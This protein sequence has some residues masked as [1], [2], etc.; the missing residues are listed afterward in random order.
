MEK[1]ETQSQAE[2]SGKEIE[3]VVSPPKLDYQR[4]APN[5]PEPVREP[6]REPP[7][8]PESAP[9]KT[10]KPETE[11]E[12]TKA[13][14]PTPVVPIAKAGAKRKFGDENDIRVVKVPP[15][16]ENSTTRPQTAEKVLSGDI[17]KNRSI[18][19][20]PVGKKKGH[21]RPPLSARSTNDDVSS[22]RKATRDDMAKPIK[23]Q[24]LSTSLKDA[25]PRE[26]ERKPAPIPKLEI[27][28]MPEPTPMVVAILPELCEPNTPGL[29]LI[30]P[31][32]PDRS[33]PRDLALDT[34]PP[35]HLSVD[36]ETSRPS[37]RARAAISYA[38]PNLR[39]K[40]RRPTKE[41][42]DA[43]SGEGKFKPRVS[44]S[45]I[46]P[47][48]R[49]DELAPMSASKSG[50][51]G[52]ARLTAEGTITR[53]FTSQEGM[54]SPL[55]QRDQQAAA[56]DTLPSSV[57]LERRR[58]PS[59][60]GVGRESLA[61]PPQVKE[62]EAPAPAKPK[63][64]AERSFDAIDVYD[65]ASSSPA[66]SETRESPPTEDFTRTKR[67]PRRASAAANQALREI[68]TA[69]DPYGRETSQPT[70]VRSAGHGRKRASMLAP[71][72]PAVMDSLE[73]DYHDDH[74]GNAGADD[75]AEAAGDKISRRRSMML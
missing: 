48:Q 26:R 25:P 50:S 36:G 38:E 24:Q 17:S 35:G 18:K 2:E 13:A 47:G 64:N 72:R 60:V 41:L 49:G 40:M 10:T 55:A 33:A 58:R 4:K 8:E 19:E 5:N 23:L 6:T 21:A 32:T 37:R 34:P 57:V 16:K 53:N 28:S 73:A 67:Q 75:A 22:P 1:T 43:V 52:W 70:K 56:I 9:I 69:M 15:G 20:L 42:F 7:K 30:S 74:S 45:G 27:P 44:T 3:H 14:T 51:E 71:K 61:A 39:D 46:A 54:L 12:C 31:D 29:A 66:P 65:F 11:V 63:N 59:A 62:D 68:A